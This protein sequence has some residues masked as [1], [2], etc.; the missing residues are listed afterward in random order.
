MSSRT[1]DAGAVLSREVGSKSPPPSLVYLVSHLSVSER[2]ETQGYEVRIVCGCLVA[3]CFCVHV[4]AEGPSGVLSTDP[5]A[6]CFLS[7]EDR[8]KH[9]NNMISTSGPFTNVI[10][11]TVATNRHLQNIVNNIAAGTASGNIQFGTRSA[12]SGD[13]IFYNT[14]EVATDGDV[15]AK[16]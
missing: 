3:P 8:R 7:G 9:I 14:L 12:D 4:S 1:P 13:Y 15:S 2:C 5:C 11:T 10:A 16:L 6:S